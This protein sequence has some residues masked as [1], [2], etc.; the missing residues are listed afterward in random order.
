MHEQQ[1]KINGAIFFV[2]TKEERTQR[3]MQEEYPILK[4]ALLLLLSKSPEQLPE[5]IR[6]FLE[7]GG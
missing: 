4:K 5:D 7:G 1:D 3:Q 6:K 2:E